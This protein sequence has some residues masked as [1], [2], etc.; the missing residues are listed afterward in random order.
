MGCPCGQPDQPQRPICHRNP[1]TS[2]PAR[3]A[4]YVV[5]PAARLLWRT[6]SSIQLE[7]GHRALVVDGVDADVIRSLTGQPVASDAVSRAEAAVG[8]LVTAG[9]LVPSPTD[10]PVTGV[11]RL[12]ADLGA[13]RVRH[14]PRADVVLARRRRA[15][16]VLRGIGR[17][18]P[19]V[20]ALLAAAGVGRVSCRAT[21]DA[22]LEHAAP[23][24]LLP[25]DE[26]FRYAA[27]TAAAIRR[28]APDCDTGPATDGAAPD[29]VILSADQ[30]LD[31]D[32]QASLHAV[33]VAHLV[34]AGGADRAVIGP[35]VRPG[36]SSCLRCA[37]LHRGDRD[38]AWPAF[39][40]QLA[41]RARHP[42]PDDVVLG[43][44]LA[45]LAAAQALAHLDG[46]QPTTLDGTL[47]IHAPQWQIRR[48]GWSPHPGCG[49][50]AHSV[51]PTPGTMDW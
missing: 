5:N 48:R 25:D 17:T 45:A 46:D 6:P 2:S 23:G 11:P 49:C 41:V 7:L 14:G 8:A 32:V 16:V 4:G 33:G 42:A 34:V 37:D 22:L 27:A 30:A 47:E 24:G 9:F 44:V 19:V 28:A 50:G 10:V 38:R 29:L 1:V 40:V 31:A 21:G 3:Y 12:A 43:A 13:L 20:G 36:R 39:A 35:L 15:L 18:L 26:G 51:F